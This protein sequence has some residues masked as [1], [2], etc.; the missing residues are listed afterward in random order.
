M[1]AALDRNA[2]AAL[3]QTITAELTPIIDAG[4]AGLGPVGDTMVTKA[5][6]APSLSKARSVED[7]TN[8]IV[9]LD[10]AGQTEHAAHAAA[11]LRQVPFTGNHTLY[12]PIRETFALAFRRATLS[13]SPDAAGWERLLSY[14][15]NGGAPGPL[16]IQDPMKLRLNGQLLRFDW[17]TGPVTGGAPAAHAANICIEL[18]ELATMWAFGGSTE[19]NRT[20]IDTEIDHNIAVLREFRVIGH[21]TS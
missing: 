5:F 15:E 16:V 20:R 11:T 4:R 2:W 17:K 19:W 12:E 6:R 21:P 18:G 8:L 1:I 10:A 13:G 9:L 7:L 3:T 14:G